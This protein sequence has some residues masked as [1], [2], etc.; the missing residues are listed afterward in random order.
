MYEYLVHVCLMQ[1]RDLFRA[2]HVLEEWWDA[3][4]RNEHLQVAKQ[5]A[6]LPMGNSSPLRAPH[7]C[8][9][10][11]VQQIG[12]CNDPRRKST[13][14]LVDIWWFAF[15][16]I[17]KNS[18]QNVHKLLYHCCMMLYVNIH[19]IIIKRNFIFKDTDMWLLLLS[20]I[21]Q[22]FRATRRRWPGKRHS[23]LG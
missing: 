17:W 18:H 12:K 1:Y 23:W 21:C 14:V 19:G 9:N 15:K 22:S 4:S 5:N 2:N 16:D 3:M 6:E 8:H 10:C 7:K 11:R 20:R 13:F